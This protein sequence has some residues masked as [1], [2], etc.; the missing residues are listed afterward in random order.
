MIVARPAEQEVVPVTLLASPVEASLSLDFA[1]DARSGR[2][3][4]AASAQQ[5]PLRVVRAFTL[6]DGAA[7][8]HLHNVSG[9]LLGGDRLSLSVNAG[10]GANVQLTTTGATRIYRP[11]ADAAETTQS[12]EIRIARNAL[13]EY[14]PDAIIPFAGARFLQ[15][16]S[17]TLE[18]GAGLFWW[19]ILAPGREAREE[20]F[21]YERVEMKTEIAADGRLIAAEH[22]RLE[23]RIRSLT[24]PARLG[25]YRYWATFYICRAGLAAGEW[26]AAEG[27][28]R[29][30][31]REWTRPGETLWGISTLA[32]DGLIARGL[33]LHGRDVLP[34]LHALWRTAKLLLYDREAI[35]PRKVN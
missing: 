33:A 14:L 7:L 34:G 28:L 32:S 23:P 2:T 22:I 10:A 3:V 1:R 13:V 18:P 6:P 26:L 29:E 5:P 11:R 4:L 12:N 19:E 24:S 27:A 21:E 25:A 17:V 16:T 15:R 20:V 35:P 9:G 31:A 30:V 8:V